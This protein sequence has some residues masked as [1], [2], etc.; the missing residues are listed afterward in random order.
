MFD[1][2]EVFPAQLA[3]VIAEGFSSN[4]KKGIACLN[5]RVVANNNNSVSLTFLFKEKEQSA[6]F[7]GWYVNNLEYG[8]KEF[9]IDVPMFGIYK[10]WRCVFTSDLAENVISTEVRKITMKA[11]ILDDI[12]LVRNVYSPL[13]S[14]PLINSLKMIKGSGAATFTRASTATYMENGVLKYAAVDEP[15]FEEDGILIETSSTNLQLYS[16]KITTADYLAGNDGVLIE[17]Y[18]SIDGNLNAA[19]LKSSVDGDTYFYAYRSNTLSVSDVYTTSVFVNIGNMTQGSKV[20]IRTHSNI[21]NTTNSS[22]VGVFSD[23]TEYI[24]DTDGILLNHNIEHIIDDWYR[25]QL[26]TTVGD[27]NGDG[28]DVTS[29]YYSIVTVSD[30]TTLG[31]GVVFCFPQ[32]EKLPFATSFIPTGSITA[33]RELEYLNIPRPSDLNLERDGEVAISFEYESLGVTDDNQWI[34]GLY[35]SVTDKIGCHISPNSAIGADLGSD[36]NSYY[37]RAGYTSNYPKGKF[38]MVASAEDKVLKAYLNGDLQATTILQGN[39]LTDTQNSAYDYIRI[40]NYK[41]STTDKTTQFSGHLK[42]LKI[43][44]TLTDKEAKLL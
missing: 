13:L 39:S 40:G 18:K 20:Y 32:I 7:L 21:T 23:G 9:L 22:Y 12:T 10:T 35:T 25:L 34:I 27:V 38:T 5:N 15:R 17:D 8:T 16:S 44:H 1:S 24:S 29:N 42:N 14:M 2:T 3:T 6:G 43:F 4:F 31:D 28:S 11:R 36:G 41:Q 26:T 37:T 30:G 19:L 33:T